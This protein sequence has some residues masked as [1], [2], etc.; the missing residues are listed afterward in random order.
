MN[1]WTQVDCDR[2]LDPLKIEISSKEHI[3]VKFDDKLSEN[4][5]DD[6]DVILLPYSEDRIN[7][8]QHL[9]EFAHLNL[10]IRRVHEVDENGKSTCNAEMISKLEQYLVKN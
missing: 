4:S 7:V 6:N 1:G 3:I 8:A 5:E 9:Y 2:C 10:P